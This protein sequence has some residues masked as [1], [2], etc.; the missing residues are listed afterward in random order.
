MQQIAA[1]SRFSIGESDCEKRITITATGADNTLALQAAMDILAANGGGTLRLLPGTHFCGTLHLRSHI[2]LE[3]TP[4]A[5]LKAVADP[6]AFQAMQSSVVSRMD[7]VPWKA[8]LHAD[9]EHDIRL[10]GGGV[11][12]GSG[13]EACFQDGV[14][15]SPER[16]YGLHFIA[17]T[18]V[19]VEDLTL[20]NSAFWLQRYFCCDGVRLHGLTIWN[21]SNKNN[22][23]IDVDSSRNVFISDCHIDASDDGICIKSEGEAIAANIVVTNCIVATHASALK[24]GTGSVGGFENITFSNIVL[25][26][27]VSKTMKHPLGF[28]NG[29]TGIDLCTTDGGPL[30]RILL[31]NIT[32]EG[33]QCPILLRHG[34]R[35]SGNVTRQ[36]YG[37]TGDAEQG[38]TSSDIATTIVESRVYEDVS[39]TNLVARDLGP[40][41][42]IACGYPGAPLRRVTLRDITLHHAIAGD[43]DDMKLPEDYNDSGYPGPGMSCTRFPAHGLFTRFVEDL[44]VENLRTLAAEGEPRP[45]RYDA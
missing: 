44:V 36:G 10:C 39:I 14:E 23:G 1:S 45:A 3:I 28:W 5:T 25:R 17:C 11:I 4:G 16:P 22:D 26:R 13:D 43:A 41:P 24:L 2:T 32:M 29:L 21:H 15:N 12:D 19:T 30:R 35:L 40:Y 8:F 34:N 9:G 20:R 38:V 27:S 31:S 18:N 37:G 6:S 42:I 33:F 7:V